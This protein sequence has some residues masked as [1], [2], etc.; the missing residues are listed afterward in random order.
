VAAAPPLLAEDALLNM[1]FPIWQLVIGVGVVV[2]LAVAALRLARRG[3]SRMT[4]A[5]LV[6]AAAIIGVNVLNALFNGR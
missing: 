5:V 1:L 2:F 3:R 4:T 6:A